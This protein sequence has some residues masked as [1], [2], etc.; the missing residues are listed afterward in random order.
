MFFMIRLVQWDDT[1]FFFKKPQYARTV[2][3]GGPKNLR[4]CYKN[5]RICSR[6]LRPIV[7]CAP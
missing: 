4:N 1:T 7:F 5:Y 6:N 2:Y 3:V